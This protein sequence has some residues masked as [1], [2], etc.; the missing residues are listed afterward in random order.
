M[1]IKVNGDKEQN[2][3]RVIEERG[4]GKYQKTTGTYKKYA[5]L[6]QISEEKYQVSTYENRFYYKEDGQ[7]SFSEQGVSKEEAIK[8][9]NE[10]IKKNKS[11]S[12][13]I[14]KLLGWN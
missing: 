1:I 6:I 11:K 5:E 8:E 4:I 7:N 3:P 14:S 10:L 12:N 13:L 9:F 2:Y